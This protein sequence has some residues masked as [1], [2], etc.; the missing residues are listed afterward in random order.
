MS[1]VETA[2]HSLYCAILTEISD[3]LKEGDHLTVEIEECLN[4]M[5]KATKPQTKKPKRKVSVNGYNIFMKEN[6]AQMAKKEP[7]LNPQEMTGALAKLWNKLTT[8][9][10]EVYNTKARNASSSN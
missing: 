6:R 3:A 1:V 5:K 4:N 2:Y 8:A 9:E 10:K 7:G